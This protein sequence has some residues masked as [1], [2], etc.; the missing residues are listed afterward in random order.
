MIQKQ[1]GQRIKEIDASNAASSRKIHHHARTETS[2]WRPSAA[3]CP[4]DHN[5]LASSSGDRHTPNVD[6]AKMP[7]TAT[8]VGG[9][10]GFMMQIYINSLR[11]LPLLR[12]TY[13]P[14]DSLHFCFSPPS[15]GSAVPIQTVGGRRIDGRRGAPE[16]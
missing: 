12:S 14:C 16:S 8:L 4:S 11:K 2:K 13:N 1:K 9:G 3:L 10:M 15:R 7:A 6:K 5:H